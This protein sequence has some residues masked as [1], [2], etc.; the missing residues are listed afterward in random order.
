MFSHQSFLE[1][2]EPL[3]FADL[4]FHSL[5]GNVLLICLIIASPP[6][7]PLAPLEH[8]LFASY[9]P[10]MHHPSLFPLS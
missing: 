7:V 6:S 4:D 3:Q 8:L 9:T 1:L 5:L 2:G 10:L